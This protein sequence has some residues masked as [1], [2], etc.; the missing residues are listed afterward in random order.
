MEDEP[1]ARVLW[2]MQYTQDFD[3][4]PCH[5]TIDGVSHLPDLPRSLALE[6]DVLQSVKEV[7]KEIVG[8][9]TSEGFMVFK[10]REDL[11][12]EDDTGVDDGD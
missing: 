11:T 9:Q 1:D 4:R 7:W 10:E 12:P 6:D 5:S 3:S 8:E 2:H